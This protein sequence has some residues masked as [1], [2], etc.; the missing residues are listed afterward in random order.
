MVLITFVHNFLKYNLSSYCSRFPMVL[1][2][3]GTA[4]V[5]FSQGDAVTTHTQVHAARVGRVEMELPAG[6]L[7]VCI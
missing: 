6:T 5:Q 1:K 7:V 3:V 2:T 4:E